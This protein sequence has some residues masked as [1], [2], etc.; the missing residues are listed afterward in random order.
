MVSAEF[1]TQPS[2]PFPLDLVATWLEQVMDPEIPVVS[3][4]GLGVIRDVVWEGEELVVTVTPTY[5][6]CPATR[7]I[8]QEIEAA[9]R[10]HGVK[11]L[12]IQTRLFPPW[13]T[14]WIRADARAHLL[15]WGI[16]PPLGRAAA[17]TMSGQVKVACP[18]CRS[19]RTEQVS[20]FGS[21]PCKALHRCHD[22]L[23][24]FEYFK[25]I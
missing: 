24:P 17:T 25:C 23:E 8:N 10:Q 3:V 19:N 13:T 9:L 16:V 7:V 20:R 2:P 22:C 15:A 18:H 14:D 6:G 4:A 21:T 12:R 5:S 1:Q 11:H